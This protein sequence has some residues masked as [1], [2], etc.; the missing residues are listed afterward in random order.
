M[1]GKAKSNK[2]YT[3]TE[4]STKTGISMPTLQRY[5]KAYQ[6]RIPSE[7]QGRTQKYPEDALKVFE[8][9][10]EE[11]LKRRGRPKKAASAAAAPKKPAR[12]AGRKP[13]A[14]K[15]AKA[16]RAAK[17]SSSSGLLTLTAISKRTGIS[18][19]TLLRYVRAHLSRIP[20]EGE[21]RARRFPAEAI[22]V[23]ESIRD[24][25]GKRRGG[26]KAG[27]TKKA[28]SPKQAAASKPAGRRAAKGS[29]KKVAASA[30]NNGNMAVRMQ[31]LEKAHR[32]LVKEISKLHKAVQKPIQLV[33]KR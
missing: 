11:N 22:A 5:K 26:R 15:A 25:T 29:A 20:H 1:A 19:P 28:A 30:S 23:F 3:L 9:L 27:S 14:A 6:S 21:G 16:P 12:K 33:V 13:K 24:E 7:G 31:A 32:D 4:V 18:Y 17:S 2:L 10:K 8:A